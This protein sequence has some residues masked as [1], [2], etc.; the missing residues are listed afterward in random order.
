MGIHQQSERVRFQ[1]G[2]RLAFFSIFLGAILAGPVAANPLGPSV[3]AGGASV[4][5]I[6]TDQVTINQTTPQAIL[7]WEQFNI[8]PN[9]VTRFVQPSAQAIAL[10]RIFDASPSQ[11]LGALQANG[12]VILLN[13]N[14]VIFGPGAQVNVNGLIASSLNLTDANFLSGHYLFEGSALAGSVQNAGTIETGSGG[15]V[16][17]LAPNVENSG[18]IRSPE[19]HITLAAGTTAYLSNRPDGRGFLVEVTAPS[20]EALNLKELIA[21]GGRIN[22]FGRVVNQSGLIRANSIREQ[23]GRIELYAGERIVLG[24]GSRITAKGGEEGVSDGGTVIVLADK[25]G[26]ETRFD[27]GAFIDVSGGR[28]G[29]NGGFVELSGRNVML[30]GRI[31]GSALPGY[32]GGTLLIDPH[33]YTVDQTEFDSLIQNQT[34]MAN[35]LIE[36]EHNLR[37]AGVTTDPATYAPPEGLT[38]RFTA[39]GDLVFSETLIGSDVFLLDPSLPIWNLVGTAGNR[40]IL[41]GSSL[42]GNGGRFDLAAGGNIELRQGSEHSYLWA[43]LGGEIFLKAGGDLI[44]PSVLDQTAGRN[45]Y[46]GIRLGPVFGLEE[47]TASRLEIDVAGSFLG[48]GGVLPAGPGFVLTGGTA[49]VTVGGNIGAPDN[50]ANLTLGS[51]EIRMN[52]GGDL[53][54]GMVQD[55]GLAEQGISTVDP[56]NRTDFAAGG[57]IH[58]RPSLNSNDVLHYLKRIYPASFSADA[59]GSIFIETGLSFWP[60]LTGSLLFAAQETI[61]GGGGE[62]SQIKLFPFDPA[63]VS[64]S[65]DTLGDL[66][67]PP[68][69]LADPGKIGPHEAQLV[70]FVT[71]RG[72][73]RNLT[74]DFNTPFVKKEFEI[75]SGNDLANVRILSMWVPEGME[76][77]VRAEGDILIGRS[78]GSSGGGFSFLGAGRGII[79]AGGDLNLGDSNGIRQYLGAGLLDISV[80]GNL[81]MTESSIVTYN[82]AAIRIHGLDGPESAVVGRVNVGTNSGVKSGGEYLG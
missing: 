64:S 4:S 57:N 79:R 63:L 49:D 50:Y 75:A 82:G 24:G 41:E 18:M 69:N 51:G 44:A 9:E 35:I 77:V 76:G 38:L 10:N 34:G 31:D 66:V 60:S 12:S 48:V 53:Y 33:D 14:G 28:A 13:P 26:G 70:R 42:V 52:A 59:G 3:I 40:I 73:I 17:L 80:G 16:Y 7:Q 39:G 20:G 23:S 56:G 29:G 27:P 71:E 72:D 6:G 81:E 55:W 61:E 45:W 32:R 11:I 58:L 47:R 46:S 36:A 65:T 19:G 37:V 43:A 30:G 15:F 62:K 2:C 74:F 5:G 67:T 1:S 21:D 22:L 68:D 8:A 78:E 25:S 54:L